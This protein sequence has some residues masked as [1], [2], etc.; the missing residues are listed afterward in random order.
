MRTA[1]FVTYNSVGR[2]LVNGLHSNGKNQAF[3]FQGFIR[4]DS[5]GPDLAAK[6]KMMISLWRKALRS[7][8]LRKVHLVVLY[9]GKVPA[10]S[11]WLGAGVPVHKL[12]FVHCG[13][14]RLRV[15][16]LRGLEMDKAA[17]IQSECGGIET[18]Y[19]IYRY[20]MNTGK[21]G[22]KMDLKAG[23]A[24]ARRSRRNS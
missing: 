4:K 5:S 13:C 18:L 20:F 2:N 6:R 15:P 3:V 17:W 23:L 22:A 1:L 11:I 12:R 7:V 9:C 16:F 10:V 21:I 14:G 24:A 8:D 19:Q